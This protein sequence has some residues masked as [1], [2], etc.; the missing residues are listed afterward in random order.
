MVKVNTGIVTDKDVQ[1]V[2]EFAQDISWGG[3][4]PILVSARRLYF[5]LDNGEPLADPVGQASQR[6]ECVWEFMTTYEN[7][8]VKDTEHG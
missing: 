5:Q 7:Q 3:M 4:N 8:L 6:L 2:D 1:R